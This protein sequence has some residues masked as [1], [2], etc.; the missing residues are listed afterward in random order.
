MFICEAIPYD[1][2]LKKTM[3]LPNCKLKFEGHEI[4]NYTIIGLLDA[5]SSVMH[6]SAT[7]L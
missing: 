1:A 2:W 6:T 7:N 3:C 4:T 5:P